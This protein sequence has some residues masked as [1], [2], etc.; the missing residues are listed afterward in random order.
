M[1]NY[2]VFI[3]LKLAF[4]APLPSPRTWT[5]SFLSLEELIPFWELPESHESEFWAL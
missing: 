1:I 2:N 3:D 5:S 4:V